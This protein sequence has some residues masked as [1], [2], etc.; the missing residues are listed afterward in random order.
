[1]LPP[2][3]VRLKGSGIE[4]EVVATGK[5][6]G[7]RVRKAATKAVSKAKGIVAQGVEEVK[8]LAPVEKVK[9]IAPVAKVKAAAKA[10]VAK[11]KVLAPKVT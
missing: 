5:K 6:V 2:K 7:K 9:A 8:I 11:G 1:M 3:P 10:A 4:E